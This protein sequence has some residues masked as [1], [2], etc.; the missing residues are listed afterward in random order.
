ML[1]SIG[2][3]EFQEFV[4]LITE[5]FLRASFEAFGIGLLRSERGLKAAFVMIPACHERNVILLSRGENGGNQTRTKK[6]VD[7]MVKSERFGG[8]V[9]QQK[10]HSLPP[11]SA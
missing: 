2:G 8:R 3:I 11:D 5:I 1:V 9:P 10:D 6:I 4:C 7:I